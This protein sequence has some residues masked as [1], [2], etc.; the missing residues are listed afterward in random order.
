MGDFIIG[1]APAS[2]EVEDHSTEWEE[3]I[4]DFIT[5][6]SGKKEEGEMPKLEQVMDQLPAV[7]AYPE[8]KGRWA[9]NFGD[10][11]IESNYTSEEKSKI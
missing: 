9:D 4:G 10:F 7:E 1:R 11:A 5:A 6:H 8:R 3:A 2:V